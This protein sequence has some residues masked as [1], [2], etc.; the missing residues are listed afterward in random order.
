MRFINFGGRFAS[1]L[2]LSMSAPPNAIKSVPVAEPDQSDEEVADVVALAQQLKDAELRNMRIVKKKQD[3]V[4]EVK[5][6]KDE[7]DKAD[8]LAREAE[9]KAEKVNKKK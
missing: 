4:A 2:S 9:Q 6:K 1:S 8:R 5:R 3:W 7:Q